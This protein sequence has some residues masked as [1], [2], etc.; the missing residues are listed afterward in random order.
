MF[1][2]KTLYLEFLFFITI[3]KINIDKIDLTISRDEKFKEN[4]DKKDYV[5][6]F[7]P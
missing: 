5:I 4:D 3:I 1:K 2:I 6:S 7:F